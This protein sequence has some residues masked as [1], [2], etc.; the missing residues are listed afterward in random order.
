[1]SPFDELA[2]PHSVVGTTSGLKVV[3]CH[4]IQ[5]DILTQ[6]IHEQLSEAST[7]LKCSQ[8]GH[9]PD[10]VVTSIIQ[11]SYTSMQSICC[12]FRDTGLRVCLVDNDLK[13][14]A[15]AL[16][17]RSSNTALVINSRAINVESAA[18]GKDISHHHQL[19]NFTT[20]TNLRGRGF[21]KILLSHILSN[22]R[23]FSLDGDGIWTFVEPPDILLYKSLGFEHLPG[24]ETYVEGDGLDHRD[25]NRRHLSLTDIP[26]PYPADRKLK[27]FVMR[28]SWKNGK[29]LC[30]V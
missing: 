28:Q 10:F 19:F 24:L 18:V 21:G 3:V 9:I 5:G 2:Q 14:I 7:L 17:A 11:R 8:G 22:P 12:T 26:P 27:C 6:A 16:V 4:P 29:H 1:M 15:T 25:Y 13:L 23:T 20:R 30:H